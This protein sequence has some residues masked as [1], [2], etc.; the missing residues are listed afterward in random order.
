[1]LPAVISLDQVSMRYRLAR[2]RVPSFKEY[3]I[4]FVRGTLS[5][6]SFWALREISFTVAG[7]ETLG[8][9]GR[10]GAGKST[11]LK[12]I[13]GVLDPTTGSA[14]V[15]GR[16]APILELGTGFDMELTGRENVFLNALLLGHPRREIEQRLEEIVAFAELEQFVD[17]PLRS[18]STGMVAR[19][20]FAVA[21]AWIPDVLILD[22]VFAVGDTAFVQKCA[23]RFARFRAS[24][25][26]LLLVSH[27]PEVV[28]QNCSRCLWIDHGRLAADGAPGE[29]LARYL[30]S[31]SARPA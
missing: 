12:I 30:E 1:M 19:L 31:A 15:R 5:Y 2:Q 28:E 6:E 27:S 23:E 9:V 25:T 11:L 17:S 22:E 24:G 14:R 4:H 29:V 26:T 13:A 21:T 3:A 20:G 16:V 8:I 10:N 7:G 18:Y